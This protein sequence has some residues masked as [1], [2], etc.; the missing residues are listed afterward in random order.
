[1]RR[2]LGMWRL[3]W[4][5]DD[6]C[7]RIVVRKGEAP[8]MLDVQEINIGIHWSFHPTSPRQFGDSALPNLVFKIWSASMIYPGNWCPQLSHKTNPTK[9]IK[10]PQP[11]FSLAFQVQWRLNAFARNLASEDLPRPFLTP[12][13]PGL[14]VLIPHYGEQ[15]LLRRRDLEIAVANAGE[16]V[17]LIAWLEKR[18]PGSSVLGCFRVF[19]GVRPGIFFGKTVVPWVPAGTPVQHIFHGGSGEGTRYQ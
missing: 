18:P 7:P 5:G 2:G 1:M 6:E 3:A 13:V 4:R 17:P 11:P 19:R 16:E 8:K 9:S 15:I 12:Y 14:T 10:S